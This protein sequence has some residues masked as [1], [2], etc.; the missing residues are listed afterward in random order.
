[1]LYPMT[2]LWKKLLMTKITDEILAPNPG[3]Q[4]PLPIPQQA[5][6]DFC[7]RHHIVK[8]SLFGSI[9]RDDFGPHSDVD[10]LVEFEP[11]KVPSFAIVT[12]QQELSE[13][14]GGRT[15]DLR[16]PQEL[17]RYI[18]DRILREAWVLYVHD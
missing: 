13:L 15:V 1:M 17:S 10:I 4:L 6:H 8:L 14:L 5:I 7:R 18:R 16:T 11:S 3:L 12:M 9:L 2:L